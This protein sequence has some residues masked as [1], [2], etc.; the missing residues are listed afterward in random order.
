MAD[1]TEALKA[2]YRNR[3]NRDDISESDRDLGFGEKVAGE[4]PQRLLNRDGSFNVNRTGFGVSETLNLYYFLLTLKWRYFVA[5]TLLIYFLSNVFFG[6]I[7]ASFGEQY[8]IDTSEM[9]MQNLLLRGFF[10]SVQT[11]ATIGYGTIHPVG[12]F[13]N[14][15]V[16]LESYYSLILNA[17]LTGIV[18]A[19]F[20]RPSA[21]IMFSK[22]AVI[23]PY[24]DKKALMIRLVNLRRH[25]LMDVRANVLFT[26]TVE[27]EGKIIRK[28]DGLTL[29]RDRVFFFP[30][31]WT[32]VHPIDEES[33][34]FG[35]T[36]D[37]LVL[38]K[39]ELVI[40]LSALDETYA[41][42]V[43]ART[44]YKP[45]EV[46]FD[47]KFANIYNPVKDGEPISINIRLLSRTEKVSE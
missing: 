46:Q 23:A 13:P 17:L 14:L 33:P 40:L 9:P 30:L 8:L 39:S 35:L 22:T 31:A 32:V 11:F 21:K 2:D 38:Y 7:Y 27:Q 26:R 20:A 34:L 29:E 42:T 16:T 5:L 15:T 45:E 37:E 18:F 36:Y 1:N 41:Q 24:K 44:S 3:P 43:H 25:Q 6:A 10:F 19:R 4:S 28:F 47:H 12:F